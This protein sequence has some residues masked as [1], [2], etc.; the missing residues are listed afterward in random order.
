[1]PGKYK[2]RKPYTDPS[3]PRGQRLSERERT[4]ILTLYQVAHWN[5]RQIARELCLPEM[6]VR[7]CITNGFTTPPP[8]PQGC[9]PLLTT[10]KRK[11]LV[12]RATLD[13]FHRRLLYEEIAQLEGIQACK[14]SLITAFEREQYHCRVAAEKPLLTQAHMDA[15]LHWAQ[16]YKH[17]DEAMWECVVW[18]D[19]ASF[20]TGGFG[21]VYVTRRAEEK[22]DNS[23]LVPKF[24]GYSAWMIYGS[25]PF[26]VFEKE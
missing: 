7:R 17:W 3:R 25:G 4:Q 10:R 5:K 20:S 26:T 13:A 16:L 14:R 12:D 9:K 21:K 1:M 24:R 23:C 22:Y 19:E 15:R 8:L 2:N 6:T 18:T 11:R